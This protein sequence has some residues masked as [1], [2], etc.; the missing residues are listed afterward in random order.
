MKI[1]LL[2]RGTDSISIRLIG[3]QMV[4][5]CVRSVWQHDDGSF[6]DISEKKRNKKMM[7]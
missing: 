1:V 4:S 7:I 2:L 3:A 6:L 5:V